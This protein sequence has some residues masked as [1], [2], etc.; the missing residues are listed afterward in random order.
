MTD[1]TQSAVEA[2]ARAAYAHVCGDFKDDFDWTTLMPHYLRK[3]S[4]PKRIAP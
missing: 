4:F 2:M 1:Q 3:I